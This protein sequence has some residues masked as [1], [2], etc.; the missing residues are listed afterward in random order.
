ML[1]LLFLAVF[2]QSTP[3]EPGLAATMTERKLIRRADLKLPDLQGDWDGDGKPDTAV[4]VVR[5]KARGV[6]V[7]WGNG[8]PA[9]LLGAG[10]AF[11]ETLDHDFDSWELAKRAKGVKRDAMVWTWSERASA[12]IK[13]NGKRFVW[14]QEGD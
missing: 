6:L 5:D 10:K 7:V 3:S 13:W 14:I 1:S 12:R 11:N 9:V 8:K 2:T 4:T